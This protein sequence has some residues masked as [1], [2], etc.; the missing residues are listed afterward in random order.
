MRVSAG[1]SQGA[2]PA[3]RAKCSGW[4]WT[5]KDKRSAVSLMYVAIHRHGPTNL[6]PL[7]H[8]SNG[9]GKIVDH[10]EAFSMFGKGVVK[11]AANIDANTIVQCAFRCQD[12]T[13]SVEHEGVHHL[14]RVGNLHLQLLA[15]AEA[16][17][18]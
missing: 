7:L 17:F 4:P 12:R 11:S 5:S 2:Q 6:A 3:M 8:G 18:H 15:R 13:S 14:R 10:A 9:N 16:A 1:S